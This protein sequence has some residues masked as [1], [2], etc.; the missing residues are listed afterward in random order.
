VIH[1]YD[2]PILAVMM[3][4]VHGKYSSDGALWLCEWSG[5]TIAAPDKRGVEMLTTVERVTPPVLTSDQRVE[6]ALRA[7][8]MVL[9]TWVALPN[10]AT[11]AEAWRVWAEGWISGADRSTRA[12]NAAWCAVNAAWCAVNAAWCAANAAGCASDAAWCAAN[13]AW[14]AV[15]AAWSAGI[16]LDLVAICREVANVRT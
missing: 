5:R 6:I 16:L 9:P 12:V 2:D 10:Q 8:L 11:N 3:D 14:C 7:N 15:D 4:L 13:A 1:C